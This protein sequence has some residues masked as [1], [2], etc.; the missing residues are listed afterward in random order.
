MMFLKAMGN[1]V[2]QVLGG[3]VTVLSFLVAAVVHIVAVV[4]NTFIVFGESIGTVIGMVVVGIG[5][6]INWLSGAWDSVVDTVSSVAS[7]IGTAFVQ[8]WTFIKGVFQNGVAFILGLIFTPWQAILKL[9]EKI[10]GLG[11]YAKEIR[12]GMDAA[13]QYVK[14]DESP[15]TTPKQSPLLAPSAVAASEGQKYMMTSIVEKSGGDTQAIREAADAMRK[16]S[17][18]PV[19]TT[20]VLDGEKV[21]S[22]L[23]NRRNLNNERAFSPAGA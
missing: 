16:V 3:L 8:A 1:V 18:R 9:A 10:P 4:I 6:F 11:G 22:L 2:G 15:S 13:I 20:V 5:D 21:N 12:L 23:D 19:Q 17:E 14:S 7:A